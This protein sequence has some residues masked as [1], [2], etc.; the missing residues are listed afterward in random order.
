MPVEMLDAIASALAAASCIAPSLAEKAELARIGRHYA[1]E[2]MLV[3]NPETGRYAAAAI[4]S[5]G[6]ESLFDFYAAVV[7]GAAALEHGDHAVF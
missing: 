5:T 6:A 3:M 1:T 7:N 4:P 2:S